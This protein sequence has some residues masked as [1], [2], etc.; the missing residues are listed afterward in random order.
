L[1]KYRQ[2]GCGNGVLEGTE[3]CDDGNLENGD[4]C[5]SDCKIEGKPEPPDPTDNSTD[6]NTT[7]PLKCKNETLNGTLSNGV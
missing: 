6:N 5:S 3:G 1:F 7:D 4:G 2:K